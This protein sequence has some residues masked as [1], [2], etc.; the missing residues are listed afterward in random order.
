[1][2]LKKKRIQFKYT[3]I[4]QRTTDYIFYHFFC[5]KPTTALLKNRKTR[6]NTH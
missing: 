1:M 2:I 6:Y 3:P 4:N 5:Q